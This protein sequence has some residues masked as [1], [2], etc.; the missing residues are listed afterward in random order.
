MARLKKT[1][2]VQKFGG[3][4]QLESIREEGLVN[5]TSGM[6][7]EKSVH[8]NVNWDTQSIESES[9]T[10][11]E[12]DA[13]HG[14]PAIIRMFEFGM[15]LEAFREV[16]PT[17]QELFNAHYKFIETALWKDG[18]KVLPEVQPRIV[19]DEKKFTYKIFV[20]AKPMKGHILRER[21]QTLREIVHG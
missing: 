12:D 1:P 17:K 11:I 9:Q 15:N 20:G 5:G 4:E 8:N 13:G 3:T 6:S 7:G 16:Q 10:K 14:N 2:E 21:P 18:L 19:V